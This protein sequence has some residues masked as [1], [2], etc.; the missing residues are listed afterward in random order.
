[1]TTHP[2]TEAYHA[3]FDVKDGLAPGRPGWY[4]AY[5]ALSKIAE[6]MKV[7]GIEV[8]VRYDGEGR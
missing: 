1:M 8:P 7:L 2:L 3:V 4:E 5:E 6:V